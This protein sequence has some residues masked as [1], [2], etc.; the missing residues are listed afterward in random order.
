MDPDRIQ[1]TEEKPEGGAEKIPAG[2]PAADP[3]DASVTAHAEA[4]ETGE[5]SKTPAADEADIPETDD[6]EAPEEFPEEHTVAAVIEPEPVRKKRRRIH[7]FTPEN[8][9]RYRGPLSYRHFKILGWICLAASQAAALITLGSRM[10]PDLVSGENK[11]LL[12]L[13][14]IGNLALPLLLFANF[15]IILNA[16]ETFKKLL[17][18][19]GAMILAILSVFMLFYERYLKG[20]LRV[21][22]RGTL[23]PEDILKS[24]AG[25]RWDGYFAFNIFVDLFLCTLFMFFLNYRP[26]HVFKGRALILFR[27]M[28]LLPLAYEVASIL[29]KVQAGRNL[30]VM[31]IWMYPLLTTKPP[32]AF[33]MFTF[34]ALVLKKRERRYYRKGN[35]SREEY[36]EFW[37]SNINSWHF[38]L[39]ASAIVLV[40]A[41]LDLL[42]FLGLAV[43]LTA[44]EVGMGS[45]AIPTQEVV[46]LVENNTRLIAQL[47]F[48]ET[49]G[50]IFI[51]PL[52][53]L[54]SYTRK[55]KETLIDAMIPLAGIALISMIYL[56]GGYELIAALFTR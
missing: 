24:V 38:S 40:T 7:E 36:E 43:F 35:R 32:L 8:D 6:G 21:L 49:M 30:L 12:T 13:R 41:V 3:A 2:A 46:A 37:R 23:T 42:L 14:V 33:L 53:L 55:H 26:K 18:R 50:T 48:G 1:I 15:A 56:E 29:L 51:I 39:L 9:I 19:Y 11:M 25:G 10:T 54:F 16:R 44:E 17:A 47:G 4:P 34:I 52:L 20:F 5:T 45:M 22:S 28:A 31:P 27:L